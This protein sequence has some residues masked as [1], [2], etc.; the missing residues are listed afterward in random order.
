MVLD[1]AVSEASLSCDEQEDANRY[2]VDRHVSKGEVV[3]DPVE[4]FIGAAIR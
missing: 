3:E 2:R 4:H 1:R